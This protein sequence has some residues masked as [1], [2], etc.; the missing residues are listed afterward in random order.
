VE[1]YAENHAGVCLACKPEL[2]LKAIAAELAG[3]GKV[4][5]RNVAYL[6]RG[7][8]ATKTSVVDLRG[9]NLYELPRLARFVK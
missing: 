1:Q 7:F 8:A 3:A 4:S 2:T 9:F 5:A 6:P